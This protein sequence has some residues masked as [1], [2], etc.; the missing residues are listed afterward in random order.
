MPDVVYGHEGL[1]PN[2]S[3]R[4]GAVCGLCA[5]VC[6][7]VPLGTIARYDK[8]KNFYLFCI[9]LTYSYLC[10]IKHQVT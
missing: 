8:Q 2:Q 5:A 7:K 3:H 9:V 6:A 10:P 4:V 1:S